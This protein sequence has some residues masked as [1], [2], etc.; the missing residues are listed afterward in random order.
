MAITGA[1]RLLRGSNAPQRATLL[2]LLYDVVYVA[3]FALTSRRFAEHLTWPAAAQTLVMLT[4][5]WWTWSSIA[6]LTNFY[7]PDRAPIQT[8]VTITMLGVVLMAVAIPSAFAD[9][10]GVFAGGYVGIHLIKG[11]LLIGALRG[12]E[13]AEAR[14]RAA[15]FLFWFMISGIGWIAGILVDASTQ[16]I[17]WA[18]AAAVDVLAGAARY[19]TPWPWRG[20]VPTGHYAKAGEHFVERFRQVIILA[21]G[22]LI[23]VPSLEL[24]RSGL[25]PPRI[26]AYLVAFVMTLLLWQLF[27]HATDATP[28]SLTGEGRK[29]G[30]RLAPYT[31]LALVAGVVVTVAGFELVIR[32]PT[33]ATPVRWVCV[34]LGGPALFVSARTIFEYT[35][36]RVLS[37]IRLGWLALLAAVSPAMVLVPPVVV[38]LVAAAAV[39]GID[40][41][42][43]LRFGWRLGRRPDDPRTAD[44]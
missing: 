19:P 17:L 21:I 20:S 30:L 4:A 12:A 1:A 18:I 25:D 31:H 27:A 10:A 26:V 41:T 24:T 38:T 32:R 7:N 29:V 35:A 44:R 42:D 22:D 6:L 40:V 23:L 14:A 8:I 11:I 39:L 15:R 16:L 43:V 34:I 13:H 5:I 3:A 9:H 37:M 28:L 2:E 33:G 36:L